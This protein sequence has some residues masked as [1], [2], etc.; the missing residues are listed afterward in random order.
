VTLFEA[1]EERVVAHAVRTNARPEHDNRALLP[2]QRLTEA[3]LCSGAH[4][5]QREIVQQLS[6][7]LFFLFVNQKG[8][9]IAK[10][11]SI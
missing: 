4:L 8:T 7:F 10:V 11:S 9:S 1:V 2:G 5:L 6:E 3:E